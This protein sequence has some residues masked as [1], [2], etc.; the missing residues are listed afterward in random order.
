MLQVLITLFSLLSGSEYVLTY[1]VNPSLTLGI[2]GSM[3]I[4]KFPKYLGIL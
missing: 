2:F 1:L 4:I 3:C